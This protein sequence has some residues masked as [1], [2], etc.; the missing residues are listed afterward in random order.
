MIN[1]AETWVAEWRKRCRVVERVVIVG[2]D[3]GRRVMDTEM[4]GGDATVQ[5][6]Q[7]GEARKQ[8]H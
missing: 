7:G 8:V 3:V 5:V 4:V 2:E 6:E 1:V